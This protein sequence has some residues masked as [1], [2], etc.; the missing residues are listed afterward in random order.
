MDIAVRFAV[1]K[2]DLLGSLT[3]VHSLSWFYSSDVCTYEPDCLLH[4]TVMK[5]SVHLLIVTWWCLSLFLPLDSTCLSLT[6]CGLSYYSLVCQRPTQ[7]T[8]L[9]VVYIRHHP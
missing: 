3:L 6:Q 9:H 2:S 5:N 4:V 8:A 7:T 1:S